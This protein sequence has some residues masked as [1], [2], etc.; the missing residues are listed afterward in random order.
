M[1]TVK[2]KFPERRQKARQ[3][4]SE[5]EFET[6]MRNALQFDKVEFLA[7]KEFMVE[8]V[9]FLKEEY[10]EISN[11]ENQESFLEKIKAAIEGLQ[12][13]YKNTSDHVFNEDGSAV[14]MFMFRD[15]IYTLQIA[16]IIVAHWNKTRTIPKVEEFSYE[17][18]EKS[19]FSPFI[20]YDKRLIALHNS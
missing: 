20:A 5:K 10:S 15:K 14:A 17:I 7:L 4:I 18:H 13:A 1:S 19:D 12:H 8:R 9:D 3:H 11:A 16:Q 2:L 6:L